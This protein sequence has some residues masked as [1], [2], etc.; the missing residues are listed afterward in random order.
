M[1][2]SSMILLDTDNHIFTGHTYADLIQQLLEH[3]RVQDDEVLAA[4]AATCLNC[5]PLDVMIVHTNE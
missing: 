2:N 3:L 4:L 1:S 5:D